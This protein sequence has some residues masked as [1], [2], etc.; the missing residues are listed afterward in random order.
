MEFRP[1]LEEIIAAET[2]ISFLD[3]ENEEIVIRGYDLIK[4]AET[5]TYTEAAHLLIE[6]KLPSQPEKERFEMQLHTQRTLPQELVKILKQLPQTTHPM[7]ALRTGISV[8]A[9]F[10]PHLDERTEAANKEKAIKLLAQVPAIIAS[11]HR[12]LHNQP[13]VPSHQEL[14]YSANFLYMLTGKQPSELEVEIFDRSLIAYIEHELPNSTFT[15][16]VI[17]ST[18]ADLYGALTGAVSSLKGHLH[19]G[20]NEAVM[21]MLKEAE[22][23]EKYKQLLYQKLANKERIMGFGHRVYM[24]KMDPRALLMKKALQ[25]LSEVRGDTTLLEMCEAGETIMREEKGLYP[26]LDYYAA[27]VYYLLGIPIELYTPIFFSARTAGLCAHVI[28]QHNN[29]RLYRPRVKYVGE[30]HLQ[31]N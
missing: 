23:P 6:G 22:S 29:N 20:A 7:D 14:S 8:L 24:K 15:A 11:S 27:P 25:E 28:E 9:S 13:V 2:K 4:L 30:R 19:G 31:V 10:D 21:Y 3:V 5:K 17:S 16:R 12:L 1:G 18:H 26:N